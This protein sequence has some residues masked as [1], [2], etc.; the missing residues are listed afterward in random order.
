MDW[1]KSQKG[2][3]SI[4]A[5]SRPESPPFSLGSSVVSQDSPEPEVDGQGD[6]KDAEDSSQWMEEFAVDSEEMFLA[7]FSQMDQ[8]SVRKGSSP[9]AKP[10]NA[11]LASP[12]KDFEMTEAFW[13]DVEE[14]EKAAKAVEKAAPSTSGFAGF[15]SASGKA[16]AVSDESLAKAKSLWNSIDGESGPSVGFGLQTAR[17]KVVSVSDKALT[18]ARKLW[19]ETDSSTSSDVKQELAQ[20]RIGFQSAS[21]RQVSVSDESLAKAKALWN[22]ST[23]TNVEMK[24][25]E[26]V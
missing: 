25:K 13:K 9:R 5:E 3:G 26:S 4:E 2:C 23:D 1:L 14:E 16:V 19:N 8:E 6:K 22:D 12:D 24:T 18:K 17:G 10:Q 20:N 11:T 15:Q 21:G 7:N